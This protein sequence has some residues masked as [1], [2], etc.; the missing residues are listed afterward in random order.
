MTNQEQIEK[1]IEKIRGDVAAL[2]DRVEIYVD[3]LQSN[4]RNT[5]KMCSELKEQLRRTDPVDITGLPWQEKSEVQELEALTVERDK[6]KAFVQGLAKYAGFGD[7]MCSAAANASDLL[8]DLYGES[9]DTEPDNTEPDPEPEPELELETEPCPKP[10]PFCGS[11]DVGIE[12]TVNGDVFV[13]CRSC[14]ADGPLHYED[15]DADARGDAVR[16]WNNV[17]WRMM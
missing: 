10:C 12:S 4:I 5:A 16:A 11:H 2:D 6:L 8:N 9:G 1:Q 3:H 7:E 17:T 15:P 13:R 14:M